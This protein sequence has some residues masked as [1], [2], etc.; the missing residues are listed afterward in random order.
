MQ[1]QSLHEPGAIS[2]GTRHPTS[3][4]ADAVSVVCDILMRS[5]QTT[6]LQLRS[7]CQGWALVKTIF[8]LW[9]CFSYMPSAVKCHLQPFCWVQMAKVGVALTK[10]LTG[11]PPP[12]T[13]APMDTDLPPEA[14]ASKDAAGQV[15]GAGTA[16]KTLISASTDDHNWVEPQAFK[17]L[18]GRG[19][20]DFS[21][22]HQQAIS[23]LACIGSPFAAVDTS[24]AAPACL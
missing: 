12:L 13:A 24:L 3:P 7:C 17:S 16:V 19:H 23:T 20:A 8:H 5:G 15:S 21:S 2:N 14:I 9:H 1:T 6:S 4:M 22:G 11:A 18:V 10:G